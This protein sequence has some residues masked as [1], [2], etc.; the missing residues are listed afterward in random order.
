MVD[1]HRRP[2]LLSADAAAMTTSTES[3][4]KQPP[5]TPSPS[6]GRHA[7]IGHRQR[8]RRRS[9]DAR[10]L[11]GRRRAEGTPVVNDRRPVRRHLQSRVVGSGAGQRRQ[12]G[13]QC[14]HRPSRAKVPRGGPARHGQRSGCARDRQGRPTTDPSAAAGIVAGDVITA[15]DG[16][17]VTSVDQIK[18][19]LSPTRPTTS[20]RCPITHADQT[21]ADIAVT[22]GAAPSM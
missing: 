12:R 5:A 2:G 22:V 9:S 15:V 19:A 11:V 18:A 21:T 4:Q 17:A 1:A 8:R 20:S 3:A 10:Q 6:L 14:C 13:V 16:V 7:D